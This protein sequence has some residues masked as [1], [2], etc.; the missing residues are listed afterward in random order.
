M[1]WVMMWG[2]GSGRPVLKVLMG[3]KD[4]VHPER[5]PGRPVGPYRMEHWTLFQYRDLI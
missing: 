5:Q 3:K 4:S 2:F 1:A